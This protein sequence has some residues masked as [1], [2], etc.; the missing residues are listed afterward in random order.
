GMTSRLDAYPERPPSEVEWEE[1]L[2]KYEITPRALRLAAEDAGPGRAGEIVGPL[3][4]LLANELLT[5]SLLDQMAARAE[6]RSP[7]GSSI[8]T[9][10]GSPSSDDA[11]ALV[12][13]I[14]ALRGRNFA[15]VQRRGISVWEW[16]AER[17]GTTVT[18]YRLLL[19]SVALDGEVLAR[20]RE[21]GG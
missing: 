6:D 20:V 21:M 5:A 11:S 19:S 2:V 13:R 18:P 8:D 17:D 9:G 4:A 7:S 16:T 12:A 10:P 1:L 14:A 3:E 15:A